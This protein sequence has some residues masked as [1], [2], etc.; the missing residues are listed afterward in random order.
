M[1][2]YGSGQLAQ[3][4]A[5]ELVVVAKV[6]GDLT[7]IAVEVEQRVVRQ[8]VVDHGLDAV[9]EAQPQQ[10]QQLVVDLVENLGNLVDGIAVEDW[11]RSLEKLPKS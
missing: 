11:S 6:D 9:V 7:G 2:A 1:F 10:A 8:R 5:V 4:L 3:Q